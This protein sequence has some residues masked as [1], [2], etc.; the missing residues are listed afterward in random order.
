MG[1]GSSIC[2]FIVPCNKICDQKNVLFNDLEWDDP[3]IEENSKTIRPNLDNNNNNNNNDKSLKNSQ[4]KQNESVGKSTINNEI[5]MIQKNKKA[6]FLNSNINTNTNTNS[7]IN[8]NTTNTKSLLNGNNVMYKASNNYYQIP[9][10][11]ISHF[12]KNNCNIDEIKEETNL[13]NDIPIQKD[14]DNNAETQKNGGDMESQKHLIWMQFVS[15][16]WWN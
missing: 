15:H 9:N 10:N 5:E 13:N 7:F 12:T 2:S 8:T 4:K 1:N 11:S 6:S 14:L 3:I 16:K